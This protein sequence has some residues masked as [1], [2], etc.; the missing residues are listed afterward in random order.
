M[1]SPWHLRHLKFIPEDHAGVEDVE[2]EAVAS[3]YPNPSVN[4]NF[5]VN[6]QGEA[7]VVVYDF[8]GK[9]VFSATVNGQEE[10]K[11]NLKAGVY[12]VKVSSDNS[13]NVSKLVVR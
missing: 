10:V 4:G 1:T 7:D 12:A 11:A 5:T 6:A 9:V 2:A 8:S 13:T 3:I